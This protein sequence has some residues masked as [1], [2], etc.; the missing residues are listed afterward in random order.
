MIENIE[1]WHEQL[2]DATAVAEQ[3]RVRQFGL[4]PVNLP[5][6]DPARPASPDLPAEVWAWQAFGTAARPVGVVGRP[7]LVRV[8]FAGRRMHLGHVGLARTAAHLAGANGVVLV[9]DSAEGTGS[10]LGAFRAALD[11]FG[12]RAMQQTVVA[13]DTPPL[14]SLQHRAL[15]GLRIEKLRRLY[16]WDAGTPVSVLTDLSAM[17]GF[18]LY[19]PDGLEVAG[20]GLAL[21]DAQ[22]AA[23][24]AVLARAARVVSCASP[25]LLYRRLFP[26]LR[27]R[28][29]R[30]T[31]R[32]PDSALFLDD[33]GP[34]VHRKVFGALTGGRATVDE[35]RAKGGD[36]T[37]CAVFATIEL[38]A[39]PI[40]AESVLRSCTTGTSTCADCKEANVEIIGAGLRNVDSGAAGRA[41]TADEVPA[42][43]LR[44]VETLHRPPPRDA[45]AVESAVAAR[46]GV[47]QAQVVVGNG[48]TEVL[49]WVFR[50]QA[51]PGAAAVFTDPT[52]ELYRQLADRH[53]MRCREVR[54]DPVTLDH[55]LPA[56]VDAV[57]IRTSVCVLDVP[58]SVSGACGV[59]EQTID[60][61]AR[62]LPADG[63]LV[64]D[65]VYADYMDHPPSA[66]ALLSRHRAAVL[67]GSLSK[68][69]CLLG[70]RIGYALTSVHLAARLRE[71]RLPYAIDSLALAAAEAA[72]GSDT[73]RLRTVAASRHARTRLTAALDRLG[74]RY[75]ATGGNF[76]FIALGDRLEEVIQRLQLTG[77]KYRDGRRWGVPGW[78]QVHLIDEQQ[79]EPIVSVL[80]TAGTIGHGG[81]GDLLGSHPTATGRRSP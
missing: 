15:A 43:V 48:S 9:F 14:R 5:T 35:Q 41:G 80:Q 23:H 62:A 74:I 10:M 33:D 51:Q 67:L 7:A 24:S 26:S 34:T 36:P 25:D 68:A 78:L 57:D 22:Q 13:G 64:L 53:G 18:F 17:V 79:I 54:W 81:S 16:G 8:G 72:L 28:F 77:Q 37:R 4:R 46:C 3:A 55:D 32:D 61:V 70:A 66:S 39:P 58:H 65:L 49:D 1:Q 63:L 31:A 69:D 52:F 27:R 50:L 11:Y 40:H 44:A 76:L 60:A 59:P 56:I 73:A 38:L 47:G 20:P 6:C 42:A 75:C 19:T 71:M 2:N 29:G 21:V 45:A 30:C 12:G